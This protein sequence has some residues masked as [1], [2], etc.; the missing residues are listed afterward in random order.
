[1]SS[2]I[3]RAH[4]AAG[5]AVDDHERT[6]AGVDRSHAAQLEVVAA[7]GAGAAR[8]GQAGNLALKRRGDGRAAHAGHQ[9]VAL[10]RGDGR[11]HRLLLH[12]AVAD[13]DDIF[14]HL[15][16]FLQNDV[17]HRLCADLDGLLH[18][19]DVGDFQFASGRNPDRE[20]TVGPRRRT[21]RRADHHDRGADERFSGLIGHL[22][23]HL[24]A[25]LS[26]RQRRGRR[27]HQAEHE[28]QKI[29]CIGFSRICKSVFHICLLVFH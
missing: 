9:I 16:V 13:H 23:A 27:Q 6:F 5:D 3:E 11:S 15:A 25:V 29:P 2:L 28:T 24:V 26:L 8:N 1:M 12:R 20:T 22:A 21:C 19:A 18:I 10:D 17:E 14:Q 4:V 7:V